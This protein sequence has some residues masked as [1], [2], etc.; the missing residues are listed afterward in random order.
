MIGADSRA[1]NPITNQIETDEE[2]KIFAFENPL[3]S[4]VFAWAGIVKTRTP[5]F[6]FS[7][8]ENSKAILAKVNCQIFAED[9]NT[10]LRA[11]LSGLEVNTTGECA[12]GIFLYFWNGAPMGFEIRVFK[13]GSTWDSYVN[14]G[15]T[16]N[17]EIII[18]SGGV[19]SSEFDKPASLNQA[20]GMMESYIQDCIDDP[21]NK[22]IGGKVRIGKFTLDGFEWMP[23]LR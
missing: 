7:L 21:R 2:Q 15:G 18:L 12:R 3:I 5:H 11:R 22:E 4:V 9:F 17:G 10:R 19:E 8:V 14:G 6:D 16:P 13:N 1:L 23:A 20:K